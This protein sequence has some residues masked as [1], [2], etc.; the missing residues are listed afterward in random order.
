[1]VRLLLSTGRERDEPGGRSLPFTLRVKRSGLNTFLIQ[2]F[3]NLYSS[4]SGL[5]LLVTVT[6]W[7]EGKGLGASEERERELA[8]IIKGRRR[9]ILNPYFFGFKHPF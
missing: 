2:K 1:M 6:C 8:T 4:I 7:G 3:W 9:F 5:M